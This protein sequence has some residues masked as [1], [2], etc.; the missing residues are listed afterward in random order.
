MLSVSPS[1]ADAF[2]LCSSQISLTAAHLGPKLPRAR[3]ADLLLEL[4]ANLPR[5]IYGTRLAHCSS[6]LPDSGSSLLAPQVVRDGRDPEP[7]G[8]FGSGQVVT[9]GRCEDSLAL[10]R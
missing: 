1:T 10:G 6:R 9:F 2:V 5:Q 7:L 4:T 8:D 3:A